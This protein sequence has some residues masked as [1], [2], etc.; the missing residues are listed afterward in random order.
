M[1]TE[2]QIE[3]NRRNARRSTGPKTAAGRAVSRQNALKHGLSAR[4]LIV[5]DEKRG[6]F[7]AF[8]DEMLAALA[9]GDA[10]EAALAERIIL[11]A[12]RLRRAGRAEAARLNYA[13]A[14][15]MGHH[16]G[17]RTEIDNALSDGEGTIAMI[18][19]YETQIERSLYRAM[20]SLERRQARRA[21]EAVPAPILVAVDHENCETKPILPPAVPAVSGSAEASL[22][23]ATRFSAAKG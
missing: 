23:H 2:A 20:A 16:P 15:R 18:A 6:D 19:R 21:G 9:P 10:L 17:W 4:K 7:L 3:A 8:H 14:Q 1:A 12:W 13:A 11:C 22:A 5:F